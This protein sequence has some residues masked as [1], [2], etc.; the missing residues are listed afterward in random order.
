M[1]GNQMDMFHEG[2]ITL[3][4]EGGE[5]EETS[6]NEVPLGGVKEGVADDQEANLSAGEIVIPQDVAGW[7][8]AKF[9]MDLRDEAKMGYKKMEAMGQLGNADE[10][11]IPTDAMFNSGGM[12]FSIVDLEYIDMND[13]DVDESETASMADDDKPIDAQTGALV[14]IQQPPASVSS[15]NPTTGLPEVSVAP[16][17]SLPQVLQ[18]GTIAPITTPSSFTPTTL[19]S[20]T[21]STTPISSPDRSVTQQPTNLQGGLP[22]IQQ[23]L[24]G[25]TGTNYYRNDAGQ[26]IQIPIINGRQIYPTPPGFTAYDPFDPTLPDV[27]PIYG[28][29]DP[30]GGLRTTQPRRQQSSDDGG[31]LDTALSAAGTYSTINTLTGGALNTG[32]I[33]ILREI[34][35]G[36]TL[37]EAGEAIQGGL[38]TLGNAIVDGV[39]NFFGEGAQ[40][41]QQAVTPVTEG[42][43]PVIEAAQQAVTPVTEGATPVIEAAQTLPRLQLEVADQAAAP[44]STATPPVPPALPPSTT[45]SDPTTLMSQTGVQPTVPGAPGTFVGDFANARQAVTSGQLS[46]A[47]GL[48]ASTPTGVSLAGAGATPTS[49]GALPGAFAG[50]LGSWLGTIAPPMAAIMALPTIA[51][52][53]RSSN[54]LEASMQAANAVQRSLLNPDFNEDNAARIRAL[55]NLEGDKGQYGDVPSEGQVSSI[56]G[57]LNRIQQAGGVDAIPTAGGKAMYNELLKEIEVRQLAQQ[58]LSLG[59]SADEQEQYASLS[60]EEVQKLVD[61]RN[62]GQ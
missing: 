8:G 22:P 30:D 10:A 32:V 38:D 1:Y 11:T 60:P 28:F 13:N 21:P 39:N 48:G 26:T 54:R 34:P 47:A 53:S 59:A 57:A 43:T 14:P 20:L 4:D 7:H 62:T 16:N 44:L 49:F 58:R 51:G 36:E 24:G 12:P 45:F 27:D 56:G 29:P 19:S 5:I 23:F 52:L 33:N 55:T 40:A 6:G 35:G 9:F 50:S 25:T 61:A 31:L 42:A 18:P 15:I 17:V 41:A 46:S 2:G 37:I 3:R